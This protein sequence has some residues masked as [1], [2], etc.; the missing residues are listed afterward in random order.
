MVRGRVCTLPTISSNTSPN[1]LSH[2]FTSLSAYCPVCTCTRLATLRLDVP[3]LRVALQNSAQQFSHGRTK[4]PTIEFPRKACDKMLGHYVLDISFEQHYDP[5]SLCVERKPETTICTGL[6][7]ARETIMYF[8][9]CCVLAKRSENIEVC[10]DAATNLVS[11]KERTISD[12]K[13]GDRFQECVVDAVTA[14]SESTQEATATVA[15]DV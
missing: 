4:R 14:A 12:M 9:A 10:A 6:V 7:Y 11:G 1:Q 15:T 5:D 3:S 2:V 8:F 13:T